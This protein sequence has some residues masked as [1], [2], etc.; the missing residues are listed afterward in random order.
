MLLDE[1]V[2][3]GLADALAGHDIQTVAGAE[4]AGLGNGELLRRAQIAFDVFVTTDRNLQHQQNLP[5]FDIAVIVL[6]APTN[7]LRDLL[8]LVPR[9]LEAIKDAQAGHLVVLQS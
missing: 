8:P 6:S 3:R 9:L 5:R 2:D 4:W 7:R 1:C